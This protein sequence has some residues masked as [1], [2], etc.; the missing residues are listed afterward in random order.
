MK[1]LLESKNSSEISRVILESP[2]LDLN[3][4]ITSQAQQLKFMPYIMLLSA[5]F[6]L[7]KMLKIGWDAFRY[8][9]RCDEL[10]IP[11]L[12][13][14]SEEDITV[15]ILSSDQFADLRPDIVDYLRLETGPHAA[16]WNKNQAI[17][18]KTIA[19]FMKGERVGNQTQ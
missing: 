16:A 5:K 19:Q 13:I 6:F 11:I 18:E 12:L 2:T 9:E 7:S 3:Q 15:P 4:I 8:L 1:Y 17:I 10:R 14:H